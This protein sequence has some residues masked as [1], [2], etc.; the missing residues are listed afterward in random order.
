MDLNHLSGNGKSSRD[1][2]RSL[3]ILPFG[4]PGLFAAYADQKLAWFNEALS[5]CRR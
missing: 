1:Y 2:A 4:K 5:R 3:G